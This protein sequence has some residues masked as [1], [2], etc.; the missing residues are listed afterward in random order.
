[1]AK[2]IIFKQQ[3]L[4]VKTL[5]LVAYCETEFGQFRSECEKSN[6]YVYNYVYG[7]WAKKD[8]KWGFS[9]LNTND[10]NTT[11]MIVRLPD[12]SD[13]ESVVNLCASLAFIAVN[14]ACSGHV[15]TGMV[16]RAAGVI[17]NNLILNSETVDTED[18]QEQE[19]KL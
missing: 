11:S 5:G 10:G 14:N 6:S 9:T 3:V 13:G 7:K 12:L 2:K 4:H 18:E 19:E 1:M 8:N 15:D 17:Y 16:G